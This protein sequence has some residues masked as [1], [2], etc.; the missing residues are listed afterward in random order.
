MAPR[1]N[2]VGSQSES[3]AHCPPHPAVLQLKG[4]HD[5]WWEAQVPFPSQVL[6]VRVEPVQLSPFPQLTPLPTSAH[7][8]AAL[9]TPLV[10]HSGPTGQ[11][12]PGSVPALAFPQT[13]SAEASCLVAAVHA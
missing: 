12:S 9:H 6:Y 4:A 1:Q 7:T 5:A 3:V 11:R 8:P 10:L 13:P 2:A